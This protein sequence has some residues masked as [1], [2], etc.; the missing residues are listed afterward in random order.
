MWVF[1]FIV[2]YGIKGQISMRDAVV[3]SAL[4]TDGA[5]HNQRSV[6]GV[7]CSSP[8][9]IVNQMGDCICCGG[10]SGPGCSRRN[11]CFD[12]SCSNGG[13]CDEDTGF[14]RC[15]LSFTGPQCENPS[16][17]FRGYYDKQ[18][19][20]CTCNQGFAGV[21]CEQCAVAPANNNYVCVPSKSVLYD[22]YML[23]LLPSS[24]AADIVSGRKKPDPSISYT[25]I[26]PNSVGFDKQK[27]GCDCRPDNSQKKRWIS[28]GNLY[29][30]NE[31]IVDCIAA[32]SL[33]GQQMA[34][35]TNMWY[36]AYSLE[37]QGLLN[38]TWYIVGIVFIVLFV[39]QTAAIVLYCVFTHTGKAREDSPY[40]AMREIQPLRGRIRRVKKK[41]ARF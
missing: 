27:Y 24:F 30:Y 39:L 25:G 5:G 32:S 17:S 4:L 36:S 23:M 16:C 15:P 38:N 14:C 28:N 21:D 1:L 41:I 6:A 7:A 18:K 3:E 31:T 11:R 33:S 35:L 22:G 13:H 8:G 37:Q 19:H 12:V 40:G 9:G 34:E 29:L 20:R 2:L 26:Y 10:W